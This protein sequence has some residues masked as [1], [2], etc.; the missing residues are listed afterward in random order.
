LRDDSGAT[1][2]E[3]GLIATLFVLG[4]TAGM[5]EASISL[6]EMFEVVSD[7]I[8]AVLDR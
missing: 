6:Q 5:D 3:Y 7:T 2:V 1:A 4:A 8:D